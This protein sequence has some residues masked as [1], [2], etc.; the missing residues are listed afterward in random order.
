[1]VTAAAAWRAPASG[2]TGGGGPAGVA[3]GGGRG[4]LGGGAAAKRLHSP[5]LLE[6]VRHAFVQ[7]MDDAMLVSAAI[8]AIATV[9]ALIFLPGRPT[10]AARTEAGAVQE[11]A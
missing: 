5:A 1:V 2:R 10:L 6:S 3:T 7:G 4:V 11:V 8:A 9:L